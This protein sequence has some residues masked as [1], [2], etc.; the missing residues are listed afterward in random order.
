MLR[1]SEQ[2]EFDPMGDR[3]GRLASRHVG[4]MYKSGCEPS[5]SGQRP[6]RSLIG[7]YT[8]TRLALAFLARE[9]HKQRRLTN[10]PA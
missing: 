2:I 4:H 5:L 8:F 1:T 6:T 7:A 10:L 9:E 3:V